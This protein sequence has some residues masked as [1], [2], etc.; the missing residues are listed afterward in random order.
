MRPDT[1]ILIPS[2]P[3]RSTG[4][5]TSAGPAHLVPA[6]RGALATAAR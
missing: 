3:G 4:Q 1:S 6:E 5:G 2:W